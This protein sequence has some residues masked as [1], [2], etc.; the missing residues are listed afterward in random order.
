MGGETRRWSTAAAPVIDEARLCV[1]DE[2]ALDGP[3]ERHPA[4][5]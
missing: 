2:N 5:P 1:D 4:P 3:D